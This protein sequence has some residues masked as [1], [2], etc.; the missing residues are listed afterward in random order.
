MVAT[1]RCFWV[2]KDADGNVNTSIRSVTDEQLPS[3]EVLIRVEF[4]SLNYKDALAASGNPGVVRTLPHI[5]GIDAAGEV[6]ESSD[7]RFRPGDKVIAT[8]Y[9]IGAERWGGWCERLRVPADWVIP[10]PDGLSTFEAMSLGTAGLTAALSVAA[11]QDH[12]I[13][14]AAGEIVITGATG[15]VGSLAV[16]LLAK[17]GYNVVAVSGKADQAERLKSW[18]ARRVITRNAVDQPASKPLLA[19]TWAG[20]IDTVGGSIL[21]TLLRQTNHYGCVTCCGMVAGNDLN[22]TVFPFILR[23][24]SLVGISTVRTSRPRRDEMWRRLS[25]EWKLALPEDTLET[26]GLEQ[27][28]QAIAKILQGGLVGRTVVDLRTS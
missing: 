3:G 11:L 5:P 9:E 19:T 8:S 2:E 17:L 4:S 27:L 21:S 1:S 23:G 15:G 24:V 16:M 13:E 20:A 28:P 18:G 6:I 12:G 26:I 14:P 22:M 10:L 25:S 7:D